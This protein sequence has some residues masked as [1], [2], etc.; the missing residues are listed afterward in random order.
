MTPSDC[1]FCSR[2][3]L[4]L[5]GQF[6]V[7]QG[8]LLE[9]GSP[10]DIPDGA[11]HLACLLKSTWGPFWGERRA[12]HLEQI[13]RRELV[14]QR[15]GR[16]VYR[17]PRN[18]NWVAV[19]ATGEM[20]VWPF[21]SERKARRVSTGRLISVEQ[22]YNLELPPEMRE[23]VAEVQAELTRTKSYPLWRL[24]EQLGLA[25]VMVHP[26]A[27]ADG[28]LVYD[29]SL[30]GDWSATWLAVRMRYAHLVPEEVI[31]LIEG[32]DADPARPVK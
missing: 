16:R 26:E 28:K 12:R 32:L 2:L 4:E 3:V 10:P 9:P 21:G 25:D 18:R 8:Y 7:L 6:E 19:A 20:M 1:A 23:L 29:R 17:D 15:D 30:R 27:L 5:E 31:A 24:I 14:A 11:C 22:E 13:V